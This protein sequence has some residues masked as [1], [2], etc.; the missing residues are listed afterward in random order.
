MRIFSILYNWNITTFGQNKQLKIILLELRGIVQ[1]VCPSPSSSLPPSSCL[2]H[3]FV[4]HF[5]FLSSAVSLWQQFYRSAI[6]QMVMTH[7]GKKTHFIYTLNF[8]THAHAR[9]HTYT[10][11]IQRRTFDLCLSLWCKASFCPALWSVREE[12][13]KIS[14]TFHW[15]KIRSN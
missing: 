11:L 7:R 12:L 6:R 10:R 14:W 5:I 13:K 3:L 1:G 15:E 4:S 2:S 9:T 8:R